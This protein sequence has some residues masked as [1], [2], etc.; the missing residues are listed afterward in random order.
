VEINPKPYQQDLFLLPMDFLQELT[1]MTLII[2]H[3]NNVD[4]H[5]HHDEVFFKKNKIKEKEYFLKC[6]TY[7][8]EIKSR[9]C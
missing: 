1:L 3:Y 7:N 6:Q 4:D 9:V 5:L 8:M 2:Y